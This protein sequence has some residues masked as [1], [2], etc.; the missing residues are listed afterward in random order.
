VLI[1]IGLYVYL[2]TSNC[3][4]FGDVSYP[5]K[6]N[7]STIRII[8]VCKDYGSEQTQEVFTHELIHACLHDHKHDFKTEKELEDHLATV[9]QQPE[10]ALVS[11]LAACMSPVLAD[12]TVRK[13]L[14]IN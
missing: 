14:G 6:D 8:N 5:V 10:E 7:S 1:T 13:F 9:E 11:S 4:D 2:L 12:A 3:V